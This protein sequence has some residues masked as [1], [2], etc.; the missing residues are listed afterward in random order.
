MVVLI[1]TSSVREKHVWYVG[2][3]H[4]WQKLDF[5]EAAVAS[6]T[7]SSVRATRF[8][9]KHLRAEQRTLRDVGL[10]NRRR[11]DPSVRGVGRFDRRRLATW[12]PPKSFEQ[13]RAC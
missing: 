12:G 8:G 13:S 10:S 5:L 11:L 7:Q 2:V 3:A 1:L 9:E 6:T 4:R